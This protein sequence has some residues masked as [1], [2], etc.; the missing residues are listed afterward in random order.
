MILLYVMQR[1]FGTVRREF[2]LCDAERLSDCERV[3]L[4][5]DAERLW[6]CEGVSLLYVIQRGSG[7]VKE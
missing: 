5:C 6:D 7:T 3:I 2:S 1:E 4:L